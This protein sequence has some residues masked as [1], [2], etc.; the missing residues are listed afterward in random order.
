MLP[1]VKIGH[2]VE[3]A[4]VHLPRLLADPPRTIDN[5]PKLQKHSPVGDKKRQ[6]PDSAQRQKDEFVFRRTI[7][8]IAGIRSPKPG[9][10][11]I[12]QLR[13]SFIYIYLT[14][15]VIE[16][17]QPFYHVFY[18]MA[19]H[20]LGLHALRDGLCLVH[21]GIRCTYLAYS[22]S[23]ALVKS[24]IVVSTTSSPGRKPAHGRTKATYCCD[25]PLEARPGES[26]DQG[27]R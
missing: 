5:D 17:N 10:L 18:W 8:E 25:K 23:D 19:P 2:V 6:P 15:D 12:V 21:L 20:N 26:E 1:E 22:R 11:C 7:C 16:S 9:T 4:L 14:T 3:T 24:L 27:F 13:Q